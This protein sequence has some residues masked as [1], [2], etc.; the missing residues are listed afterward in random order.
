MA[1]LA[2]LRK[3]KA[4]VK[5]ALLP[6]RQRKQPAVAPM[7]A[8]PLK[9]FKLLPVQLPFL[10]QQ[11][12]DDR[13]DPQ[14]TGNILFTRPTDLG[15][16]PCRPVQKL[17]QQSVVHLSFQKVLAGPVPQRLPHQVKVGKCRQK[18]H[19]HPAVFGAKH[20]QKLQA[21]HNRHLNIRKDQ[22]RLFPLKQLQSLQAVVGNARKLAGR[23]LGNTKLQPFA[24]HG[25]IIHHQDFHNSPPFG[26][27]QEAAG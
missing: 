26:P 20:A 3:I 2:L 25:F 4:A 9:L 7:D 23:I 24:D 8:A 19:F 1:G 12:A 15:K 6:H 13:M 14:D 17:L 5:D 10:T 22:I 27:P 16:L 18:H 21:V 11:P